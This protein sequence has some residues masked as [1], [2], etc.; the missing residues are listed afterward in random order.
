MEVGRYQQREGEWGAEQKELT[1]EQ[2]PDAGGTADRQKDWGL[3]I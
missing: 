3:S 1:K 2:K